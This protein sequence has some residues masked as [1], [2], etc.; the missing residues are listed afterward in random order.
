M[1]DL[2]NEVRTIVL[3]AQ[4]IHGADENFD[5]QEIFETIGYMTLS[6]FE[7]DESSKIRKWML[8]YMES[9]K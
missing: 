2:F 6:D 8:E 5:E 9:K 7:P 4:A 3:N 1:S